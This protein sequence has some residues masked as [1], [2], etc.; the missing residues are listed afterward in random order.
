MTA[1]EKLAIIASTYDHFSLGSAG[2]RANSD[3]R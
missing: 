2:H 1:F 3:G